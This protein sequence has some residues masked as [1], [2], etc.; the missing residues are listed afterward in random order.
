MIL[1]S[2]FSR[3]NFSDNLWD[4]FFN[5]PSSVEAKPSVSLMHT[6]IKELENGYELEMELPGYEKNN[7]QIE[8]KEGYLT[9]TARR[10]GTTEEKDQTS[11]YVRRERYAGSCQRSFF[12]GEHVKQDD[13][14]AAFENGI[15]KLSFPKENMKPQVEEKKF[16]SIE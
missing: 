12:I 1:P 9:I 15:L 16:I 6:D 4:D 7:I 11:R 10:E 5:M 13:I 14:R 8:L 2:L 3:S